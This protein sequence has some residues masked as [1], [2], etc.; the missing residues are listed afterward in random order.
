M[1][2]NTGWWVFRQ[3]TGHTGTFY[4]LTKW[5]PSVIFDHVGHKFPSSEFLALTLLACKMSFMFFIEIGRNI[6]YLN[7]RMSKWISKMDFEKII[8]NSYLKNGVSSSSLKERQQWSWGRSSAWG[9]EMENLVLDY[10][11]HCSRG[12]ADDCIF[13]N[14]T[15]FSIKES[16]REN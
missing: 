4:F 10:W 12:C 9:I 1:W 13:Q 3:H 11:C 15:F 5:V 6:S 14:W 7:A 16:A 2:W 8:L